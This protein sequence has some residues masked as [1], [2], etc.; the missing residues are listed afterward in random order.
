MEAPNLGETLIRIQT[1]FVE[2]PELKVTLPQA[3]R[4]WALPRDVCEAALNALIETKFLV[5]TPDSVYLRRSWWAAGGEP[6]ASA[7]AL[8]F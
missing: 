2:M 1:E 7:P 8:T 6:A 3:Q 5:R 4:L